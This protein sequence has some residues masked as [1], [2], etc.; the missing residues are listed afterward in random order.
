MTPRLLLV[1]AGHAHLAVL[2]HLASLTDLDCDLTLVSP[3]E[4]QVYSGMV[5]GFIAGQYA[6]DEVSADV[7]AMAG[8][9][10]ATLIRGRAMRLGGWG[11]RRFWRDSHR[12]LEGVFA[13]R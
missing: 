3:V 12:E 5:P 4:R 6:F 9:A 7:V 13:R 1:G 10:R 8:A 2:R 11:F